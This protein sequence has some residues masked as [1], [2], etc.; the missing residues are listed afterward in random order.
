MKKKIEILCTLGPASLNTK[1][2]KFAKNKISLLRLNMSHIEVK[3]LKKN[4]I[5]IR[6]NTNIPICIDTEGAQIRTKINKKKNIKIN[7]TFKIYK[8]SSKQGFYPPSV[9][10]KLKLNDFLDIGF[11]DLKA[12]IIKKCETYIILKSTS[13]GV[14]EN[15]KGVYVVNRIL[16]LNFLT[17]KDTEAIAIAKDLGIKNFALS[18]TNTTQDVLNFK[19]ILPSQN[20]IYKIESKTAIKNLSKIIKE[21]KNFLIDRGDL[22]KEIEIEN[23][24]VF[25]RKI[26][27]MSKKFKNKKVY[28][29]TNF[30]ENMVTNKYPTRGEANDI[31]SSL[32]MGATGL[33]LAAETAIGKYPEKTVLF[34]GK[35]IKVF[36]SQKI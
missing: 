10:D 32:E 18:F 7:Q 15:N 3:D 6:T 13:S 17:Q 33:V 1:F 14:L 34:L 35:M 29:A 4:I 24:P 22:S 23:I 11:N 12:K 28:I 9:F 26:I 5:F 36:K 21:G 30:L 16:K 27:K 8:N 19:R 20:K 31:Y 2:L 25:Q